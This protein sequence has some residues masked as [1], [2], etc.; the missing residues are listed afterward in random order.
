MPVFSKVYWVMHIYYAGA[1]LY[2]HLCY[3]EVNIGL[4]FRGIKWSGTS[5]WRMDMENDFR[6][7]FYGNGG[8]R[9]TSETW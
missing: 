3:N 6:I 7:F 4:N 9:Y 5:V 8:R 2:G 1:F